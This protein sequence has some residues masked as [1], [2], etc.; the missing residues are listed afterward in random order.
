[1]ESSV[2]FL[3]YSEWLLDVRP[4]QQRHIW[5]AVEKWEKHHSRRP[6]ASWVWKKTTEFVVMLS[7]SKS[8]DDSSL[9]NTKPKL[10]LLFCEHN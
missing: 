5:M 9:K 7:F 2:L 10:H 1:M 3:H 4:F 8:M 6:R